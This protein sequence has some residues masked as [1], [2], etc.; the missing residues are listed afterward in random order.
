MEWC[1]YPSDDSCQRYCISD[2]FYQIVDYYPTRSSAAGR[3]FSQR[4]GIVGR[5]F[6]LE[7][8]LGEGQAMA[9]EVTP[10]RSLI[11][12][13]GMTKQEAYPVTRARPSYLAVILLGIEDGEFPLG[14][15]FIDAE[16]EDRFGDNSKA[17]KVA[18]D[19]ESSLEVVALRKSLTQA[20]APL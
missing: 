7:E 13:W 14:V 18:R 16:Q 19:L 11:T 3:R 12:E 5:C 8:S 1:N 4:F 10:E 9:D 15:L 6:R 17:S 2:Y 20:M